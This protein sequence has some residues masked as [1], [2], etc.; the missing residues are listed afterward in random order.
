MK[1]V[2]A[3]CGKTLHETPGR[4]LSHGICPGCYRAMEAELKTQLPEP[5]EETWSHGDGEHLWT[6]WIEIFRFSMAFHAAAAILLLV[7]SVLHRL[8]GG[9]F[10]DPIRW[11]VEYSPK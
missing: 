2:C 4:D 11:L 8:T 5:E 6:M 3:W 7:G 9:W 10:P 1:T